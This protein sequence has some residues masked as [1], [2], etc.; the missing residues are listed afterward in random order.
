L[1]LL[2]RGVLLT[3]SHL[4]YP[5]FSSDVHFNDTTG[6]KEFFDYIKKAMNGSRGLEMKLLIQ[7]K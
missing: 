4:F 2:N 7:N 1:N 3:L 5:R 6:A